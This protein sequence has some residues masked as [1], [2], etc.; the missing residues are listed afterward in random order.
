MEL[1]GLYRQLGRLLE[2]RSGIDDEIR[3]LSVEVGKLTGRRRDTIQRL[4]REL[5][6]IK[7]EIVITENRIKEMEKV[8]NRNQTITNG[9]TDA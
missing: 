1:P 2:R 8:R 9:Q 3:N 5:Q 4:E 7:Q 6:T